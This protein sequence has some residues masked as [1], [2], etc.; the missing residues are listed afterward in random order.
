MKNGRYVAIKRSSLFK[1]KNELLNILRVGKVIAHDLPK[2]VVLF[3]T[4]CKEKFAKVELHEDDLEEVDSEF[5][6]RLVDDVLFGV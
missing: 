1:L 3:P 5:I 4:I 6:M 2:V